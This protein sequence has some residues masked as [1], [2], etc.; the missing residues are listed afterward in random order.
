KFEAL[1]GDLVAR[2]FKSVERVLA[3]SGKKAN[4]I[5]EIVLVGGSTRMPL[6]Q[7]KVEAF[8]GKSPNRS[9]NPDE[10]VAVGAAV[11]G[12]VLTGEAKDVVLLD[13]TPLSL[14]IETLGGVFTPLLPR[15]T[16]IPARRSEVFSTADDNQPQVEVRVLQGER[17]MA[18]DNKALGRFV[19]DGIAAAPRGTPQIEVT[20]DIDANGIV[21]VSAKD[22]GT[23]K[24][25]SVRIEASSGLSDQEIE[26][27]VSDA[28]A[29]AQ[30]DEA[31]R[32]QVE[33]KNRLDQ[34]SYQ[35]EKTMKD[36]MDKLPIEIGQQ[37]SE[38]ISQARQALKGDDVEAYR[39]AEANLQAASGKMAEHLYATS[40]SAAGPGATT[41]PNG[42]TNNA[43]TGDKK[44]DDD[45][46]I[47]ADFTEAA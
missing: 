29:N 45:D 47:D 42:S 17:K 6:V 34:L 27:M 36:S 44:K 37:V 30:A 15:N 3:D 24:E 35:V 33:A 23:G 20:F 31:R 28:E 22:K 10:V 14:G 18:N 5:D 12:A 26:K 16:T 40:D 8:F 1:V 25:Q 32:E 38:A 11:Q 4:E 43:S 39:Q 46:V 2:S 41:A 19:L 7:Q 21:H 9:V 13:V